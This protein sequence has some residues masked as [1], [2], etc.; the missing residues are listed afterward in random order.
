MIELS[1][2]AEHKRF[3]EL[4]YFGALAVQQSPTPENH[5]LVGLACC[6]AIKPLA[7]L[8]RMS[9]R[10][11]EHGVDRSERPEATNVPSTWF[12]IGR[13]TCIVIEGLR[14]LH[15]TISADPDFHAPTRLRDVVSEV[16][17]DVAAYARQDFH[18]LPSLGQGVHRRPAAWQAVVLLERFEGIVDP[19]Q[20]AY[21]DYYPYVFAKESLDNGRLYA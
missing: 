16:R 10:T 7:D 20:S 18:G 14:H 6:A 9:W 15:K 12:R 19:E 4:L 8:E 1:Q 17:D 5:F 21:K 2:L 13:D 11:S 3:V